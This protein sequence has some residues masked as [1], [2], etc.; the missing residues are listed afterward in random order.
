M[1]ELCFLDAV[2]LAARI[3]TRQ[4]SA[5]EVVTAHLEQIERVNPVVNAIVTLL[6]ERALAAAADADAAIGSG[7]ALGPLHGLPIAHKDTTM[8][9][10]IR[11][12][13]GSPIY[14]DHVPDQDALIIERLHGAGAIAIGKTNVPELGAGSH[15]FN[16]IFGPTRNPYDLS[17]TAGGSSGGAAVA[18]ACGMHPI[19]DG[20]DL[21]GSLRNPGNFNN[22]VGFRP[23]IGR[24]PSWPSSAAW[25]SLAVHGPL[26]RTVSDVALLLTAIAGPDRR[27]PI[28]IEQ[29]PEIFA[30]PL[31]REFRGV[32]VAWSA[33]LGGLPVDP[34]V[35][36]TLAKQRPVFADLGCLVDDAS[37]DLSGANDV[38]QTLRAWSFEHSYG[39]LLET[40]R[41]QM[42]ETVIWN[43][44]RGR[45]LTGRDMSRAEA[46]R[47]E[48]VERTRL[49]FEEHEFL[50]APV[51]QVP[52][53][54][55]NTEYPTEIA[56]V[57]M[58]TYIDWM[59]SCSFIT[60]TGHPAI[61]V[62][63]GFTSEGLPV[64]L[65][66]VGRHHDDLGVLQ[67]AYAFE[68]ATRFHRVRPP[69]AGQA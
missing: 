9:R 48:I 44:E 15:T 22:V 53:F 28:A 8:T 38:F 25:S 55:L 39:D 36:E 35:I 66:I 11:T 2:E 19:A 54:D 14:R 31:E 24:V 51:N 7:D 16:P 12:T 13:F 57:A 64:G 33:D 3:R 42:K 20:S 27:S 37:P 30:P 52:P 69:V 6:P 32:R 47:S 59:Q 4:L 29:A 40:H 21:G 18:L 10:G 23:S 61:S 34:R 62:P 45:A 56:G 60:V 68:Q 17:K 1:S 50:L 49:F 26:A 58:E 41:D 63:A 46:L 65:Q 43:I 5:V 67:L